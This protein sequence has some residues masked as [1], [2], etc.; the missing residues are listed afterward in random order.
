VIP[1]PGNGWDGSCVVVSLAGQASVEDCAWFRQLL[2][3]DAAR[4]PCRI[5]VDLSGL[6]SMDRWA[7]LMLLW[8]GRVV[9]RHGGV[10]ALASPQPSVSGLLTAAGAA[11][12]V[13]VY[14]S[15]EQAVG[16]QAMSA[17]PGRIPVACA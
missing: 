1:T 3:L 8:V 5:V 13:A 2:K 10:L 9:S 11:Q 14:G 4:R 12:V 7:A 17:A 6:S 16:G 15:V